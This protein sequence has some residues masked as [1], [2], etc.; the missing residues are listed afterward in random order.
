MSIK[1]GCCSFAHLLFSMKNFAAESRMIG[2]SG[3]NTG[4]WNNLPDPGNPTATE[5]I[6][7][8]G[9]SGLSP[10]ETIKAKSRQQNATTA[11]NRW[12][13]DTATLPTT[14]T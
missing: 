1:P 12:Q 10:E 6:P 5:F 2:Q 11:R 13:D 4:D 3:P 8:T 14:I 7:Q 9:Q